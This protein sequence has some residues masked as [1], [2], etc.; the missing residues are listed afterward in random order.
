MLLAV[1]VAVA[2]GLARVV[3]VAAARCRPCDWSL[4]VHAIVELAM[5][6]GNVRGANAPATDIGHLPRNAAELED[7]GQIFFVTSQMF[8]P[9]GAFLGNGVLRVCLKVQ[10]P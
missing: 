10:C 1:A 3:A 9:G 5:F 2:E 4:D 7:Q 8:L 6:V